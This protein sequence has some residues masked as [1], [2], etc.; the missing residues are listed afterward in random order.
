MSYYGLWSQ[1]EAGKKQIIFFRVDELHQVLEQSVKVMV[2]GWELWGTKEE[3]SSLQVG[4]NS[5]LA[6]VMVEL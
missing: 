3:Q 1:Q 4:G 5:E 6:H 2:A